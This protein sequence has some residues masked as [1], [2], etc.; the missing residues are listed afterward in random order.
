[1]NLI[2]TNDTVTDPKFHYY[3]Q[4]IVQYCLFNRFSLYMFFNSCSVKPQMSTKE[5]DNVFVQMQLLM[6]KSANKINKFRE[7]KAVGSVSPSS[8]SQSAFK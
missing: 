3:V 5:Y 2:F 1:M 8:I 7:K 4:N 6:S